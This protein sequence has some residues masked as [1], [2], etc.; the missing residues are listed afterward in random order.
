MVFGPT[1]NAEVCLVDGSLING[2]WYR[3]VNKFTAKKC[4][5]S[6]VCVCVKENKKRTSWVACFIDKLL[7]HI[8]KV[9]YTMIT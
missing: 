4:T 7:H 2:V 1:I 9:H 8:C 6:L 3:F 5:R